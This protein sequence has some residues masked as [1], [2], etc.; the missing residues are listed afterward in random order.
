MAIPTG[1]GRLTDD[2]CFLFT[3]GKQHQGPKWQTPAESCVIPL[4]KGV[5]DW[6]YFCPTVL[7]ISS[8][9]MACAHKLT[10]TG[11]V[12]PMCPFMP[13][14]TIIM[15]MPCV[16]NGFSHP[17]AFTAQVFAQPVKQVHPVIFLWLMGV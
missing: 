5:A 2:G 15:S 17:A 8:N 11:L 7:V 9:S 10:S 6:K 13:M 12:K 4:D 16:A 14:P 3:M 1:L